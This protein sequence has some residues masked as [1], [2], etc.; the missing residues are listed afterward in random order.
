[1]GAPPPPSPFPAFRQPPLSTT[2]TNIPPAPFTTNSSPPP[3]P[4]PSSHTTHPQPKPAPKPLL[5][6][7]SRPETH[8]LGYN[9]STPPTLQLHPFLH[10]VPSIPWLPSSLSYPPLLP[11]FLTP[12]PTLL[13]P[14]A[15][16]RIRP[17]PTQSMNPFYAK[18]P[19]FSTPPTVLSLSSSLNECQFSTLTTTATDGY[20]AFLGGSEI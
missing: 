13:F 8:R 19:H 11:L 3:A 4:S 15:R 10:P 16:S 18:R 6:I 17:V 2:S 14:S 9:G 1:M 7:P 12:P 5:R 20:F